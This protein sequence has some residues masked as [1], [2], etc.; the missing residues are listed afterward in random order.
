MFLVLE[1]SLHQSHTVHVYGLRFHF[2]LHSQG[3]EVQI[4]WLVAEL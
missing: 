1:E 4:N 3:I 2:W